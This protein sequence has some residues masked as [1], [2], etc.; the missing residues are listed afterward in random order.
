MSH[1]TSQLANFGLAS[2]VSEVSKLRWQCRRGMRE[3]DILL[4]GYLEQYYLQA[5]P[6][7]KAAFR[8]L[9]SLPDPQ[10]AGYL[11]GNLKPLDGDMQRVV[12]RILL[13]SDS[14]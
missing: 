8:E 11:L 7:Q 6:A 5:E 12:R 10:L 2:A 1:S 4:G 3:L 9:L 13:R 14:A